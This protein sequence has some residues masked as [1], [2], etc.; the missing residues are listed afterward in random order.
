MKQDLGVDQVQQYWIK[1]KTNCKTN[2]TAKKGNFIVQYFGERNSLSSRAAK[3]WVKRSGP[4]SP[5]QMF[6]EFPPRGSWVAVDTGIVRRIVK[7]M[8]TFRFN[9]LTPVFYASVNNC[10]SVVDNYLWYNC[11]LIKSAALKSLAKLLLIASALR[12]SSV[13]TLIDSKN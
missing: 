4:H 6:R 10:Q 3:S 11:R 8:L 1:Y 7:V 9:K 13:C 2:R 12:V 5:A